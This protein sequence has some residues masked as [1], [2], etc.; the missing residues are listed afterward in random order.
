MSD[1]GLMRQRLVRALPLLGVAVAAL[2]LWQS[3]QAYPGG[4]PEDPTTVGY[5]WERNFFSALFRE[6]AWNGAANTARPWALA[7]MTLTCLSLGLLFQQIAQR[8]RH[9]SHAMAVRGGGFLVLATVFI[10]VATPL[11]D[12][13]MGWVVIGALVVLLVALR[14]VH[15]ERHWPLLIF[16]VVALVLMA[17]TG[18]MYFGALPDAI[19][20][21]TQKFAVASSAG[22][23]VALQQVDFRRPETRP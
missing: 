16:G 10:A 3:T 5:D 8:C 12:L 7:M 21:L 23:V 6:I 17:Y 2:L 15:V 13:L 22:W 18:L 11:H 4:T 1:T 14:A 19:L 20:P 9:A